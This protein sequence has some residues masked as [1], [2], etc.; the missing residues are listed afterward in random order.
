MPKSLLKDKDHN[1]CYIRITQQC[2]ALLTPPVLQILAG[3][4][5]TAVRHLDPKFEQLEADVDVIRADLSQLIDKV[6]RVNFPQLINNCNFTK[7]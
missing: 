3:R 5:S 2:S 1:F 4:Y 6:S 7:L